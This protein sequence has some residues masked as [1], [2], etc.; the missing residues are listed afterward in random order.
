LYT[1]WIQK[2]SMKAFYHLSKNGNQNFKGD[3]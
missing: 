3:F 1:A 2:T